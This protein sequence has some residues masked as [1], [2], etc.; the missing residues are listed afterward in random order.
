MRY[1]RSVGAFALVVA[2]VLLDARAIAAPTSYNAV[3]VF[4]EALPLDLATTVTAQSAKGY[5][6]R[7][8]IHNTHEG[9]HQG[10]EVNFDLGG[11]VL[12]DLDGARAVVNNGHVVVTPHPSS[13]LIPAHQR[14]DFTFCTKGN[15]GP[16]TF[17]NSVVLTTPRPSAMLKTTFAIKAGHEKRNTGNEHEAKRKHQDRTDAGKPDYCAVVKIRNL[18]PNNVYDWR[19]SFDLGTDRL[20]RMIHAVADADIQNIIATPRPGQ[21]KIERGETREITFCA[22]IPALHEQAPTLAIL[23]PAASSVVN[24]E[25][26]FVTGTYRGPPNTGITV[27]GRVAVTDGLNFYANNVPVTQG[28]NILT[29]VATTLLGGSATHAVSVTVTTPVGLKLQASKTVGPAPLATRFSYQFTGSNAIQSIA[30]DF[31]GDGVIDVTTTDR[32]LPLMF[33]YAQTGLF[34]ARLTVTDSTGTDHIADYAVKVMDLETISALVESVYDSLTGS[35]LIGNTDAGVAHVTIGARPKYRPVFTALMPNFSTI[36]SGWSP[37][38]R[39]RVTA[40][41]AEYAINTTVGG[42]D[43]LFLIYF[44][45]DEDGV[46]RL[47]SM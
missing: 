38:Q 19:L 1:S 21:Q 31:N 17:L 22:R 39:S 29:A 8:V 3:P 34:R 46:W 47:D 45:Q 11:N 18:G 27:N 14:V 24:G 37:L 23:S 12:T 26:V 28:T 13:E 44:I 33:T 15:S 35:L 5:C 7:V 32:D 40:E 43:R 4:P 30:M 16:T 42:I 41:Y 2:C 20:V 6:G 9:P 36:L 25:T 10:W